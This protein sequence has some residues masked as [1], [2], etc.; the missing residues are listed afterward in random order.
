LTNPPPAELIAQLKNQPKLVCYD[1]EI[2]Q[3]RVASWRVLFQLFAMVAGKSQFST[4]NA[5]L[6]WLLAAEPKLG[7]TATEI[8]ANSPAEWSLTR[9][10]HVGFTGVELV[11]LAVWLEST[12]FPKIG[13]ELPPDGPVQAASMRPSS[14]A[15]A[16]IKPPDK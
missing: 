4:N 1:W 14:P 11:A 8:A 12:N 6:P 16:P 15:N 2:T 13:F 10:S 7:N 9:K 5:G 3:A